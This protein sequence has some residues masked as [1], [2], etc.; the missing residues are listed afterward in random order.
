MQHKSEPLRLCV[1]G[2]FY[3]GEAVARKV[4]ELQAQFSDRIALVGIATDDPLSPRVSPSRRVWQ[5]VT[6]PAEREMVPMLAAANDVPLW[7]ESIKND[8]FHDLFAREWRPDICYMATFGQRV[9]PHIFDVPHLGFYNFHPCVD[10]AW[11]SYVGGN[12]FQAMIDAK[13]R[14][15]VL[16][17]HQ[18]DEEWDNG[19]L[20]ALSQRYAVGADDTVPSLHRKTA[21]EAANMV[22]WHIRPFLGLPRPEYEPQLPAAKEV[23]V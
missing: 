12:P 1:F 11:P 4:L 14:F 3:R 15:G 2:S 5:Y 21:A 17:M 10:R 23:A 13:E 22:E 7:R 19:A 16:A 18:V 20:I 9:P 6:E 8:A